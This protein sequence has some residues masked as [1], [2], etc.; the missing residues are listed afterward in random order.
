MYLSEPKK[1]DISLEEP[2]GEVASQKE[3]PTSVGASTAPSSL[4][5]SFL[6][7]AL[8]YLVKV[9]FYSVSELGI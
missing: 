7:D 4:N 5:A 3:V 6:T 2:G 8:D 9:S 1:T